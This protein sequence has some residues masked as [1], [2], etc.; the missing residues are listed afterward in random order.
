MARADRK[1]LRMFGISLGVV[2]LLW[3]GILWWRGHTAP[4]RWLLLA[5]PVLIAL[6]ALAPQALGPLHRVWM[7]VAKGIARLLTW[8]LLTAA[9]FLVFTPYAVILRILGRN[10]LEPSWEPDRPSYWIRR[11]DG[12][13][14]PNRT[15]K[16]Y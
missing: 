14:D 10:S 4:I 12:P 13:F 5:S 7:P 6:A 8:I 11:S 16:Q 1:E 9:F 2:C 3:S 15:L